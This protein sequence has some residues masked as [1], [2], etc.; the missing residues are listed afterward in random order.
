MDTKWQFHVHWMLD[1][2]VAIIY[3]IYANVGAFLF[4]YFE[5]Q[6]GLWNIFLSRSSF[7]AFI[8]LCAQY[9]WKSKSRV[10]AI[11]RN[12]FLD[13]LESG[14]PGAPACLGSAFAHLGLCGAV[15]LLSYSLRGP[16]MLS[17]ALYQTIAKSSPSSGPTDIWHYSLDGL[18]C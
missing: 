6:K 11:V 18:D 4:S 3:D 1:T 10:L 9:H 17:V 5:T 8:L 7:L 15:V 2:V 16:G 13:C 12:L 14:S